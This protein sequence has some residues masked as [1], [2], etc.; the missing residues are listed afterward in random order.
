MAGV[1]LKRAEAERLGHV[2]F[3]AAIEYQSIHLG[4]RAIV[5][6]DESWAAHKDVREHWT[7]VA[8]AVVAGQQP[9]ALSRKDQ[10]S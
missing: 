6:P 2:A 8:R 10:A 9:A 4:R 3:M 7:A 1:K 5:P